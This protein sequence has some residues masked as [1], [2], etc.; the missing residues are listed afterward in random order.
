[1]SAKS[2]KRVITWVTVE[3]NKVMGKPIKDQQKSKKFKGKVEF[4]GVNYPTVDSLKAIFKALIVKTKNDAVIEEPGRSHLM[5]LLKHHEKAEEKLKDCKDFTV[6]LHPEFKQTRCFFVIK[7]DGTKEDFSFH[8][9]L[10]KLV[11]EPDEE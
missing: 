9:C 4:L 2:S 8:K 3:Y 6:G 1:M 10:N 11:G 5:E 7:N